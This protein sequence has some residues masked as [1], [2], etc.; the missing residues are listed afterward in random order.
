[1]RAVYRGLRNVYRSKTRAALVIILLGLS[2]GVFITMA[3]MAERI[4][5]TASG[6]EE[7]VAT[8]IELRAAGATGMGRGVE[9]LHGDAAERL[10]EVSGVRSIERYLYFRQVDN[11]RKYPVSVIAGLAPITGELR[12][13]SHGEVGTPSI[14]KGRGFGPG[15][16]SKNL[17]VVGSIYARQQGLDVDSTLLLDGTSLKVIGIFDAGF[18]FGNNQV[19]V[20]LRVAQEL[21]YQDM[22]AL[23]GL[24][25]IPDRERVSN[26][27]VTVES[28]GQVREV[29]RQ[30]RER[31]G[32][33]ADV[34]SGQRNAAIAA[35]ALERIRSGSV[36]GALLSL[37]ISALLV[38]FTMALITRERTREIGVLK[39]LGASNVTVIRQFVTE[40]VAMTVG[41]ALLGVALFAVGAPFI[42]DSLLGISS[43]SLT[44]L[45]GGMGSQPASDVISFSVSATSLGYALFVAMAL[46]ILGSLYPSYSASRMHPAVA[47][48][49]E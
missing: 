11:N 24:R 18:V 5:D 29:E 2:I 47:L 41:G 27:Y 12:V 13:N 28:V 43:T 35:E 6:L 36:L 15:D 14:I 21:A 42:A 37:G 39:A 34:L 33:E 31:L 23:T 8:L 32:D 1:M 16:D 46:G 44:G 38:L 4:S 25:Y 19:F 26:I 49:H 10:R 30:L 7:S 40:S 17:A 48:R 9:P 3:Q 45:A 20:P 22:D